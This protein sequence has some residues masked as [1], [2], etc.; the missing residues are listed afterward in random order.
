MCAGDNGD[1]ND[2]STSRSIFSE[3]YDKEEIHR[4]NG[5]FYDEGAFFP[6]THYGTV[7]MVQK[8]PDNPDTAH[9]RVQNSNGSQF[10]INLKDRN[11]YFDEHF[12][13]FGRIISGWD[14][15]EKMK[16]VPRKAEKP[17]DPII[18][19]NSGELR[20]EDKLTAEKVD[21]VW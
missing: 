12:V 14:F 5:M 10:M 13:L 7:S 11:D 20:F 6:H 17:D 4:K 3:S 18:I 15:V 16:A 21:G 2:G 8:D 9:N 1:S 19:Y